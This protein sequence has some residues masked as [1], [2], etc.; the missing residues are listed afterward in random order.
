M[1]I[2]PVAI[3][4]T[5]DLDVSRRFDRPGRVVCVADIGVLVVRVGVSDGED[6][7]VQD[8]GPGGREAP[9]FTF[10]CFF[11]FWA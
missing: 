1:K 9:Y 3:E 10:H 6:L 4:L 5:V 11:A 7:G 2:K 8:E